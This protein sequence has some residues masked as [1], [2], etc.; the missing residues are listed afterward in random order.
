MSRTAVTF[1]LLLSACSA[2][3]TGETGPALNG[4]P[5]LA[6]VPCVT[7]ETKCNRDHTALYS[8]QQGSWVSAGACQYGCYA[9][10][11]SGAGGG[12]GGSADQPEHDYCGDCE[13]GQTYCAHFVRH[14]CTS[15]GLWGWGGPCPNSCPCG[16]IYP[17]RCLKCP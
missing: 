8:C 6:A 1:L 10:P 15:G 17:D 12:G 4:P 2:Q 7:G 14:T 9:S 16:G 5:D 3:S 13:P 11:G